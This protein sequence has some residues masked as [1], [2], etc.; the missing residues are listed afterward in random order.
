MIQVT[1]PAGSLPQL[2]AQL[3]RGPGHKT[4]G[5]S[6]IFGCLSFSVSKRA[7]V[8]PTSQGCGGIRGTADIGHSATRNK[9]IQ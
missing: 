5:K 8:M 1:G 2:T 3:Y 7:Q 6:F 4:L 9:D